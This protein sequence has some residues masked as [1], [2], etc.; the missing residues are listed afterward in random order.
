M[1]LSN[2]I[3]IVGNSRLTTADA[4]DGWNRHVGRV[5]GTVRNKDFDLLNEPRAGG[6]LG[7]LL[8][9]RSRTVLEPS[10]GREET[11]LLSS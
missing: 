9:L 2:P 10:D 4:A 5:N 3:E 7:Q 1:I 11:R 8:V 6:E